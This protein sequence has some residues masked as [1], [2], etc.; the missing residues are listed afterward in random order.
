ME[1]FS[2]DDLASAREVAGSVARQTP[3]VPARWLSGLAGLPVLLKCENLQRSGSFKVRGA[4]VRMSR[5][6]PQERELGVVAASAGNHGQGVAVAAAALGVPAT[7]YMPLAAALPK[8]AATKEYGARVVLTGD[9]VDDALAAAREHAQRTGAVLIHPFDHRDIVLGQAGVGLEI[10]EQVPDVGTILVPTGG[11]GLLAGV[12]SAVHALGSRAAVVGVQ[13]AGAAAYPASMAAGRPVRLATMATMADGIAVAEP[14]E[15]PLGI[16]RSLGVSVRTVSEESLARSLVLLM[17]RSKQVVEPAGVAGVAMLLEGAGDLRPPVVAILSGGNVDPVLLQRVLRYGLA[18]AGRYLSISV[19]IADH[20]GSLAA[21]LSL[22]ARCG[23][24]VLQVD[25]VWT[26]P[27][28]AVGQVE[29]LAQ[30]ETR[31]PEHR[32]ETLAQL[33]EAGYAPDVGGVQ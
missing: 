33:R 20:P 28:L 8:V 16:V 27:R 21:L 23:V 1:P 24:N 30:V 29:V 13:A 19:R 10:L 5:L 31:G 9:I 12:A 15:V 17:E 4:T 22:L 2:A 32:E 26:D 25:H 6:T 7:V 11:G 3:V 18:A 14:G